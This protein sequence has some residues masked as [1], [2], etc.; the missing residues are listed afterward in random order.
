MS[1]PNVS[2]L[3]QRAQADGS[4]SPKSA[5]LLSVPDIGQDI[6]AALG[7]PADQFES[8]EAILVKL[9]ID[10]SGSIQAANNVDAIIDGHN[11]IIDA[12][13]GSKQK[14]AILVSATLLNHGLL[15]PF[16]ALERAPRLDHQNYRAYGGTPLYDQSVV[17]LGQV[18]A[19]SQEFADQG[20]PVRTVTGLMT[21]GEDVGSCRSQAADVATVV[22]DMRRSERHIVTAF[23]VDNGNID[24]QLIFTS[25]GID[26]QWVLTPRN[27]PKEIRRAFQ[28]FS[29]SAVRLSQGAVMGGF[30]T[31]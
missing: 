31:P 28:T 19:K 24:F 14:G 22:K 21:D 30:N 13:L 18:L 17:V 16:T 5:S 9:L 25:M 10:D 11:G 20:I 6:G 15:Y 23:G 29:Q 3:F 2:G 8:S 7:V 4:L 12:L 27:D 1:T 26:P